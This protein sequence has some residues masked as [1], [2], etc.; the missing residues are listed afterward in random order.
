MA[1]AAGI[2]RY[3]AFMGGEKVDGS[4]G[5]TF[6]VVNPATGQVI[7]AV[8]KCT[9]HD[10][11]KAVAAA[12]AAGLDWAS[13][14]VSERSKALLRL[15][16]LIAAH[17]EELAVLETAQHGSPIRK[18]MNFD[19]PQCADTFEYFAGIGRAMTGDTLP[20]GPWAHSVTVKEP[21]GVIGLIT[22]WNFPA[23]MVAWKLAAA[24]I[25]GNTCIVKP[26]SAA[27]L[28]VL[29]LAE[30]CVEAGIPGG[31]VNV[32]TGPGESVGEAMVTHPGIA[33]IG[34]TG[35]T[36]TGKRIMKLAS[37]TA[38][39]VGLEL[40]GNN[41]LIVLEDADVDAAVEGALFGS[42][43]NTGQ[44]CAASSRL[45][46][47]ES[48]YD[49]FVTKFIEG[50]KLLR[51]G[52]PMDPMTVIGPVPFESHREKIEAYVASAKASGATVLLDGGRPDTPETRNGYF[53]LP[54][55]FGDADNSQAYM[56]D[57]IFGP[58][59]GVGKFGTNDEAMALANGTKY[60]LSASIWTKDLRVGLALAHQLQVGTVWL[61]EHLMLFCDTPWGG[62]KESGYGK[63]L[64]TMV[65]EEYV[66]TKQIYVD[67]TGAAVKPWYAI[68]K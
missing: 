26:P 32:L 60:G 2:N 46:I 49:E 27:P 11:D 22:P 29:R 28:T 40:G 68:L 50:T 1:V 8:S 13:R 12:V 31:A 52:D 36:S 24:L 19:L 25:T 14:P 17:T 10:V 43:F 67:L 38:K 3:Q 47:H 5:E 41:A 6:D 64:S 58:V 34:F 30:L 9:P 33:K 61:N 59:V 57:E 55:I 51:V 23:L 20:V 39:P 35:D 16:A 42:Y 48:L 65:L 63:D 37:D 21:L 54:T 7:A 53:V 66:H 62:C 18:T 56:Q 44:V 45:F 4:E 15:S